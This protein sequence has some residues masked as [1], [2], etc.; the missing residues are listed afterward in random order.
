MESENRYV[1]PQ[2]TGSLPTANKKKRLN[3]LGIIIVSA[4]FCLLVGMLLPAS[5]FPQ[6][7]IDRTT[8][9]NKLK[10]IGL[11]ILNYETAN[12]HFPPAYIADENGKPMHSWRVLILPYLDQQALFDRYDM[13]EPWDGPNNS[14]L[15][16]EIVECYRCPSSTSKQNCTDYVLITGLG[17][18]FEGDQTLPVGKITDGLSNTILAT[19]IVNSKIHWMQ[20]QDI[21]QKHFLA[22]TR[23]NETTSNHHGCRNAV[24]FDGSTYGVSRVDQDALRKLTLIDDGEVVDIN[25]VE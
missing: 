7:V 15:H 24:L 10:D 12:G 16:D 17:T 2:W 4:I 9:L 5:N 18:G 22:I 23:D 3:I 19:E 13:D 1:A 25:A 20:P 14:K 8:C 11:A 6:H 21:T